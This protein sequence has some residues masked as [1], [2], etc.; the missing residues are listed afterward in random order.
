MNNSKDTLKILVCVN[1]ILMQIP[2]LQLKLSHFRHSIT[3]A[4]TAAIGYE[5]VRSVR[6]SV[7]QVRKRIQTGVQFTSVHPPPPTNTVTR[8]I[9]QMLTHQ[10]IKSYGAEETKHEMEVSRQPQIP[11]AL[12]QE[13]SDEWVSGRD[14]YSGYHPIRYSH[15]ILSV[16]RR[17]FTHQCR[18]ECINESVFL[19]LGSKSSTQEDGVRNSLILR[20]SAIRNSELISC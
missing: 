15:K 7:W 14:R 3:R 13:V 19:R 17:C 20:N 10:A 18:S 12:Y 1:L 9:N 6:H 4:L 11:A 8:Y 5:N 2:P 16:S